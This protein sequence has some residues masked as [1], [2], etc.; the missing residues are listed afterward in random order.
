MLG[1]CCC[2]EESTRRTPVPNFCGGFGGA[3]GWR[4]T[5]IG[6]LGWL[7]PVGVGLWT[8][9]V[10]KLGRNLGSRWKVH[11]RAQ[12]TGGKFPESGLCLKQGRR[13][14]TAMMKDG[15]HDNT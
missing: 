10:D 6:P 14:R 4:D 11:R 1:C 2:D 15:E 8:A 3:T 9:F 5:A 7:D 12:R 13:G